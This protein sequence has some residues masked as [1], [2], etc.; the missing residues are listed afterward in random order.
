VCVSHCWTCPPIELDGCISVSAR[1]SGSNAI[2]VLQRIVSAEFV[3]SQSLHGC[4][5][6]AAYGVPWSPLLVEHHSIGGPRWE[7]WFLY[8]GLRG[9]ASYPCTL[10]EC[11]DWWIY[12]GRRGRLQPLEPLLASFPEAVCC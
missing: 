7:D 8:L 6:A 12:E 9:P 4:V 3:C 1:M 5:C 10:A 2:A 11:R